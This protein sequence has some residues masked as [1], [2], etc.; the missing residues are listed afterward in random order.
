MGSGLP[1]VG[2]MPLALSV[3][4]ATKKEKKLTERKERK[5]Y[6]RYPIQLLTLLYNSYINILIYYYNILVKRFPDGNP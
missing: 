2:N 3:R 4:T 6:H 1:V 5:G